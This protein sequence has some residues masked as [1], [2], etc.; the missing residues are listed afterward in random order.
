MLLIREFH[1]EDLHRVAK[2]ANESFKET[3]ALDFFL[4]LWGF[5]PETFLVAQWMDEIVG[6][7]LGVRNGVESAR[8]L[9][10]SVDE[11]YRHNGIGS[12]L[13]EEFFSIAKKKGIKKVSLEVRVDNREA[14]KFYMGKGFAIKGFLPSFYLDGS[15]GFLMEKIL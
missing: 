1:Y 3:Y 2:I 9:M 12:S 7:I 10:L 15:D 8:V 4:Q 14:I 6:F 13:L 11:K 5:A